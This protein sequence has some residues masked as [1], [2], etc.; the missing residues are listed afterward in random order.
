MS[1]TVEGTGNRHRG[2]MPT[3]EIYAE[4][5]SC[6]NGFSFTFANC[7]V[8]SVS[9]HFTCHTCITAWTTCAPQHVRSN[10]KNYTKNSRSEVSRTFRSEVSGHFGPRSEVSI[11]HFGLR[12]EILRHFGPNFLG[13]KC[14]RSEVSGHRQRIGTIQ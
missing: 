12:S 14:P 3:M 5:D 6:K 10:R 2:H 9:Y 4:S 8:R 1:G 11:G 7:E 13:P